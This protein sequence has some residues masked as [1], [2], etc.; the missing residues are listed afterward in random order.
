MDH[1]D[2]TKHPRRNFQKTEAVKKQIAFFDFD[3]TLTHHDSMFA[4]VRFVHGNVRFYWGMFQLLPILIGF[5]VGLVDRQKTKEHFFAHFFGGM[6]E[7]TFQQYCHSFSEE[8][9][10]KMLRQ[11]TYQKFKW[12][13]KEGHEVVLVSASAQDWL[14]DW[15][16][17]HQVSCLASRLVVKDG[18]IT[19]QLEGK[20]CHGEEKVRR[21]KEI[22][23]LSSYQTIYAYG[24][25][26]GDKPMLALAHFKVMK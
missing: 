9:I 8:I 26:S 23:D 17:K 1:V 12:H 6:P 10:P 7:S 14:Q 11:D 13:L 4:I 16:S 2:H 20:N 18:K 24:D 21:I 19:G 3:G 5:K 25:T 15:C 22:Y